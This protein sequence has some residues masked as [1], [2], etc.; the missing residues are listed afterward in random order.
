MFS[1][2]TALLVKVLKAKGAA[3]ILESKPPVLVDML[4]NSFVGEEE[5]GAVFN[6][7]TVVNDSIYK[8]GQ[9]KPPFDLFMKQNEYFS[10]CFLG[11]VKVLLSPCPF[12]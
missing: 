6:S 8:Y 5:A 10:N 1:V 4:F 7:V 2:A 3:A 12:V 9:M 11:H